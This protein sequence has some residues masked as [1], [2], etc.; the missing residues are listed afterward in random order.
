[1]AEGPSA[2]TVC[3]LG[4]ITPS[5]STLAH[6]HTA[7]HRCC[8]LRCACVFCRQINSL[9]PRAGSRE[10]T[11]GE[12]V[13]SIV[14]ALPPDLG[15]RPAPPCCL[16][17]GGVPGEIEPGCGVSGA[18]RSGDVATLAMDQRSETAVSNGMEGTAGRASSAMSCMRSEAKS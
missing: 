18:L 2:C 8:V 16:W 3:F 15:R 6:A 17:R 4:P 11:A 9:L 5:M 12:A 14:A 7:I 10:R 13:A 1:M